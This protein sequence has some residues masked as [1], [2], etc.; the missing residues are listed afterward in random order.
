MNLEGLGPAL[1]GGGIAVLLVVLWLATCDG[2]IWT[3]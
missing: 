2:A 3:R 1:I